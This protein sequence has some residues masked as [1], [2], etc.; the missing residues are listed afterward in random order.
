MAR[1]VILIA[2]MMS[3]ILCVAMLSVIIMIVVVLNIIVLRIAM[4]KSL[5]SERKYAKCCLLNVVC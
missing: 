1:I 2:I 5:Y 4:P 3:V